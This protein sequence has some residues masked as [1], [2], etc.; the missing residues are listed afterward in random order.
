VIAGLDVAAA[1]LVADDHRDR[2]RLAYAL[3]C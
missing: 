3:C 2:G 1:V